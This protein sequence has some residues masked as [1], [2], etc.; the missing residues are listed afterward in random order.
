ME[1][2]NEI[3][4]VLEFYTRANKMKDV[5][6]DEENGFS[7]A[8]GV[9]GAM[10][11]ATAIDSEYKE[12]NDLGKIIRMLFLVDFVWINNNYNLKQLKLGDQFLQ[13]LNESR[14]EIKKDFK[15]VLKYKILDQVLTKFISQKENVFTQSQ[16]IEVGAKIIYILIIN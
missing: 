7:V 14:Y 4:N 13:E 8:D 16:L 10:I 1:K 9:F 11:L 3:K 6:I 2:I 12:A 15:L 5:I